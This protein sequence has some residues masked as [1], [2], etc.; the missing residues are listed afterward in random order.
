VLKAKT[1]QGFEHTCA[2]TFEVF[3]VGQGNYRRIYGKIID[4]TIRIETVYKTIWP[5]VTFFFLGSFDCGGFPFF[6]FFAIVTLSLWNLTT[7]ILLYFD[8]RKAPIQ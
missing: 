2:Q 8:R 3:L 1:P 7:L 4:K 5:M 6:F